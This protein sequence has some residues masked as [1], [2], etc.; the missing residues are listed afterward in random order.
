VD[1]LHGT[2][3]AVIKPLGKMFRDLSGV[4]G[5]TILGNGRVALILDVRTLLQETIAEAASHGKSSEEGEDS[6]S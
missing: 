2:T 4:S 1:D 6:P 3:Q 5:S